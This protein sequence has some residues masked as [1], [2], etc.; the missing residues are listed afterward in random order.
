MGRKTRKHTPAESSSSPKSSMGK[1]S[2]ALIALGISLF[3][4]TRLSILFELKPRISDMRNYFIYAAKANDFHEIPYQKDFE[5][6]YPPLAWWTIRAPRLLNNQEI[7][8]TSD[9]L[10]AYPI[11]LD[12]S[13]AYRGLMFLY[14]LVSLAI[15][16]IIVWKR[17]PQLTGWAVLI[18]TITTA[19]LCHLLYDRLDMGLL[20]LLILAAYCWIRSLDVSCRTVAWMATAYA[21]VGLSISY[22]VI[23]I[24]CVPF[25]LLSEF[26]APRRLM[27]LTYA[28]PAL[29]GGICIP[30]MIQY[31]ISGPGVFDLFKHHAEREIQLESLYSTLMTIGSLF[32]QPIVVSHSHGAFNLSGDLSSAMKIF[33]VIL[34][35]CFLAGE[36]IWALL[37]WSR[38]S[39][40]DAYCFTCY[41]IPASVILSN[42]FSPQYL[43]W[44]F[45]LLLLL[46]IEILPAGK[47]LPW[48]L[49]AILI[50]VAAM[51]TWIFPYNYFGTESPHALVQASVDEHLPPGTIASIVLGLRNFTYLG[52]VLWMGLLLFKRIDQPAPSSSAKSTL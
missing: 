21:L 20:L 34:L 19:I 7:T 38:Y 46:A 51:S 6:E 4:F 32:G 9:P 28:L 24:I 39:R 23:P 41:V 12:Y 10:Q 16:S 48:I 36:G 49:G 17:R 8:P 13:N 3:V 40:R 44:A 15:L 42:V 22:K 26:H 45:P 1:I 31:A 47:V 35:F 29:I 27:R 37:R 5:I 50:A 33:S 43:I 2:V 25:L 52:V 18:Y 14:D 30:F 11:F